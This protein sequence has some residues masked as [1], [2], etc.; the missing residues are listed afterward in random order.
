MKRN[1]LV[2]ILLLFIVSSAIAILNHVILSNTVDERMSKDPRNDGINFN[3]H[4]QYYV[5]P[6]VI[7]L[8]LTKIDIDKAPVD[9]FRALLQTSSSLKDENL[10][11]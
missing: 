7:V 8:N 3:A 6:S 4:Y 9:V 10:I 2:A 5:N 11:S 1:I